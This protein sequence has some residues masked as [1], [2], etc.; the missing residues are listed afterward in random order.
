ML[1]T[2]QIRWFRIFAWHWERL[3][4]STAWYFF[5]CAGVQKCLKSSWR[6]KRHLEGRTRSVHV[7]N[8]RHQSK[9]RT[10][11]PFQISRK[12]R[13]F[14]WS[15]IRCLEHVSCKGRYFCHPWPLT[16][17][18]TQSAVC[19]YLYSMHAHIR[20]KTKPMANGGSEISSSGI[21]LTMSLR[22]FNTQ[23]QENEI[24]TESNE[25]LKRMIS[26]T[27]FTRTSLSMSRYGSSLNWMFS[28]R[29]NLFILL[30]SFTSSNKRWNPKTHPSTT[31]SFLNLLKHIK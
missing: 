4:W 24:Q 25:W 23:T 16:V 21:A 12:S 28:V 15:N 6:G 2:T 10:I 20:R 19:V 7:T 30:T 5:C 9:N 27:G 1:G 13:N 26:L 31:E 8:N 18:Y 14:L 3:A 17:P 22:N 11:M 29:M